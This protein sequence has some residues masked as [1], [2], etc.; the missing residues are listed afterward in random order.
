MSFLL[1]WIV[2]AAHPLKFPL[3]IPNLLDIWN[4]IKDRLVC[5]FYLLFHCMWVGWGLG[6]GT[7]IYWRKLKA[8]AAGEG[9][10]S[11]QLPTV[12]HNGDFPHR[13]TTHHLVS[14]GFP[15]W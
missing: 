5:D 3:Q 10:I 12:N 4:I 14:G 13:E 9:H 15:G 1:W 7:S 11:E 6:V 8:A 2:N